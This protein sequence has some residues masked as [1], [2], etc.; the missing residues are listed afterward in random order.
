MNLPNKLNC[1]KQSIVSKFPIILK[2]L[3]GNEYELLTLYNKVTPDIKNIAEF[4]EILDCLFALNKI[5]YKEE[6]R[7]L[8]YVA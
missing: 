2:L 4:I 1:Y 7:S 8:Y 6:K 3:E 5:G